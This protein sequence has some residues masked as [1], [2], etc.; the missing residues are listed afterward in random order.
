[1]RN[2]YIDESIC[3]KLINDIIARIDTNFSGSYQECKKTG[4]NHVIEQICNSIIGTTRTTRLGP[5]PAQEIQ[6][7]IHN[8]MEERV[9]RNQPIEVT[10]SWGCTKTWS[11]LQSR[12]DLAELFTLYQL[13]SL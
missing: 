6:N 12:I 2:V 10:I 13:K 9:S 5:L 3:S 8:R 1:M 7:E 4:K 11:I